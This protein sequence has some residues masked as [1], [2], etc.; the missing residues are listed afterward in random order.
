MVS[1]VFKVHINISNVYSDN[2]VYS[3]YTYRLGVLPKAKFSKIFCVVWFTA[4]Q[5]K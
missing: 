2:I 4:I 3:A 1:L 5:G